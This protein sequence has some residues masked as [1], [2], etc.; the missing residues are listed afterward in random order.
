[1]A[2]EA[3]APWE[4][5]P[6]MKIKQPESRPVP[7]HEPV[8]HS[9][10]TWHSNV[11]SEKAKAHSGSVMLSSKPI[12]A[13]NKAVLGNDSSAGSRDG[14]SL[15][16]IGTETGDD[17]KEGGHS[18]MQPKVYQNGRRKIE[19]ASSDEVVRGGQSSEVTRNSRRSIQ[20]V[21]KDSIIFRCSCFPS[22]HQQI[23]SLCI[24]KCLCPV[25]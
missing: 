24:V 8:W 25:L 12:H 16:A 21:N 10:G 2:G 5:E 6:L 19:G 7:N 9:A 4:H 22:H 17:E 1:M 15:T 18:S 14:A 13:Q 3:T 20:Q 11:Q 23:P